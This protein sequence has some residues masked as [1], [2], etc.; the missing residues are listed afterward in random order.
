[1]GLEHV[2]FALSFSLLIWTYFQA[3][4]N[5][6]LGR[7]K[8]FRANS[9]SDSSLICLLPALGILGSRAL[10]ISRRCQ[11]GGWGPPGLMNALCL[12]IFTESLI[13]A[14][15]EGQFKQAQRSSCRGSVTCFPRSGREPRARPHPAFVGDPSEAEHRGQH[16]ASRAPQTDR[17]TDRCAA[18]RGGSHRLT[19]GMGCWLR[20]WGRGCALL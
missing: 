5:Q 4:S 18:A 2:F 14:N 10:G 17:Q 8:L 3:G 16:G 7:I 13:T 11:E 1:M 19:E 6:F 12:L 9:S 20:A 15:W